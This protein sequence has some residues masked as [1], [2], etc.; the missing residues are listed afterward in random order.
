MPNYYKVLSIKRVFSS[1]KSMRNTLIDFLALFSFSDVSSRLSFTIVFQVSHIFC[2]SI[3]SLVFRSLSRMEKCLHNLNHD[4]ST[5]FKRLHVLSLFSSIT[6]KFVQHSCS[7][8]NFF[9]IK[10]QKYWSIITLVPML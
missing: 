7:N 6:F 5:M 10:N 8:S 9:N 3:R 2:T 1:V 4:F